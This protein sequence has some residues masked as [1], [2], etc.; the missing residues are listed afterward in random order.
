MNE[1]KLKALKLRVVKL[2][3]SW[4]EPHEETTY[5]QSDIV[6]SIEVSQQG[7]VDY[8]LAPKHPHC[9]CCLLDAVDLRK[10]IE[11]IKGVSK[12]NCTVIGIPAAEKWS[13]SING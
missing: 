3:A 1:R 11:E 13:R 2:F 4:K 12:A 5:N 9:P 10:R 7:Q 8:T 6:Q